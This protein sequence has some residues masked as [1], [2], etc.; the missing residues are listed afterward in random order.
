L[1]HKKRDFL[2]KWVS[3]WSKFK[4]F[5]TTTQF[6]FVI[7]EKES[8]PPSYNE[9]FPSAPPDHH[10]GPSIA[11]TIGWN[12]NMHPQQ[13]PPQYAPHQM[14]QP[15]MM[16]QQQLPVTRKLLITLHDAF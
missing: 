12:P 11:G 9:V 10:G 1:C 7:L 4:F 3:N 6:C 14:Q 5:H 2:S 15:L 16:Q 8:L 13:I